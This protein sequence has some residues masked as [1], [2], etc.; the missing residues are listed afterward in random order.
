MQQAETPGSHGSQN[1][2]KVYLPKRKTLPSRINS[3][4][5]GKLML[6]DALSF[7]TKH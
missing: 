4:N 7:M 2:N 6:T 3:E 1:G 5:H